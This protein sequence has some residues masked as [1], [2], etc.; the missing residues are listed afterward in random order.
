MQEKKEEDV[1]KDG[2]KLCP[3]CAAKCRNEDSSCTNCETT[4]GLR[5][6][7]K[8]RKAIVCLGGLFLFLMA[9]RGI[10]SGLSKE[11]TKT[12]VATVNGKSSAEK[13]ES[14]EDIQE[15]DVFTEDLWERPDITKV[16]EKIFTVPEYPY[17]NEKMAKKMM[18]T[19]NKAMKA[20]IEDFIYVEEIE[21]GGALFK[22]KL[23][24][25]KTINEEKAAYKYYGELNKDN[26]PDGNGILLGKWEDSYYES[27][28]EYLVP[29]FYIGEFKDGYKEGYGIEYRVD[30]GRWEIGLKYEGE[31][32]KG[33]YEGKGVRY[34][35]S[36]ADSMNIGYA[37]I[38]QGRLYGYPTS[39][40]HAYDCLFPAFGDNKLALYPILISGVAYVG[41]WKDGEYNGKGKTYTGY[42]EDGQRYRYMDYEGGFAHGQYDGKGTLYYDNGE[43]KYTGSFKGGRYSGKGTLYDE[44]G[45]VIH[46]G[47]FKNG[48]VD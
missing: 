44:Q 26:E 28:K 40:A 1:L 12:D 33:K 16:Q 8:N 29:V 39:D 27:F 25:V 6:K 14:E 15:I 45:N 21:K 32:K 9:V 17:Q 47:K 37:T 23:Y 5:E 42:V 36:I 30:L 22:D 20:D 4:V 3:E 48:E 10:V 46:K 13:K 38:L 2:Y 35:G 18:K 24:Y 19:Y 34:S 7:R 11:T 31:Y 41:D 43:V